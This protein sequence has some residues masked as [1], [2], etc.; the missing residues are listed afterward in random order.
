MTRLA[1]RPY[2]ARQAAMLSQQGLHPVLARLLVAR[3]VN[4]VKELSTGLN[5]LIPPS[6]VADR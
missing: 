4:D 6:V 5:A 2:S 1:V 3:G